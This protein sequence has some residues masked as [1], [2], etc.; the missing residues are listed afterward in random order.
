MFSMLSMISSHHFS[1]CDRKCEV[2]APNG[3][4]PVSCPIPVSKEGVLLLGTLFLK[5]ACQSVVEKGS[6]LCE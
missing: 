1:V 6:D 5:D 3:N 4:I 2:F